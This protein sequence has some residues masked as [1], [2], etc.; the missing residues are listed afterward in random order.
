VN[1]PVKVEVELVLPVK[2][3]ATPPIGLPDVLT[4]LP[5]IVPLPVLPPPM[6]VTVSGPV[7]AVVPRMRERGALAF[8]VVLPVPVA[9]PPPIAGRRT[10][11]CRR[12]GLR[13]VLR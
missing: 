13:A 10:R 5:A 7:N 3:P 8:P 2:P 6:F 4:K 12:A 11:R 9:F 1:V